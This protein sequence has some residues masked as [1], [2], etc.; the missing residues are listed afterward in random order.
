M[1]DEQVADVVNYVRTH[2]GNLRMRSR[3]HVSGQDAGS[4]RRVALALEPRNRNETNSNLPD[5]RYSA[6]SSRAGSSA[7]DTAIV[8][9][10]EPDERQLLRAPLPGCR[11]SRARL[12]AGS[13][14]RLIPARCAA[15]TFSL[16]PPT[17]S[18]RPRRLISPVI[19]VSLRT[20]RSVSSETS[21][22]NMATPA[23]GPSFGVAP[24][25]HGYG[26]RSSRTRRI[27]AERARRGS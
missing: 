26:C 5:R 24:R 10:F 3:L 18:T 12:R 21:A 25:A 2:F 7:A 4:R 17:G 22:M 16:M 15:T 19:A 23:L 13:M 9:A 20:V 27:D 1:S 8:H 11:R 6:A 14:T